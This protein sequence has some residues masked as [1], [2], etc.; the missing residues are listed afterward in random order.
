MSLPLI[1]VPKYTTE[2]PSNGEKITFRPFI[3]REQKQ[4]L[5][6]VNGDAEQQIKAVEDVIQACTWNKINI[7]KLPAYDI[8]YLFLQIRARSVGETVDLS[9]TCKNCSHKQPYKL[10]LTNVSVNKPQGHVSNIDLG[11]GLIVKMQ[12]PNLIS[13]DEL[14]RNYT[15]DGII[16]LIA[17]SIDSIWKNDELFSAKDYSLKELIEFVENLN[18]QNLT[19]IE[20]FFDSLPVLKH[21]L[22]FKCT[23][24]ETDNS[25]TLEGLQSFFV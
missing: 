2:L 11:Q 14:R 23:E 9:L 15:A 8:E 19:L 6:A 20:S 16:E 25:I 12:D 21:E 24:C 22:E 18:P 13:V 1:D 7:T 17:K 4:L 3:V 5:L 10:D